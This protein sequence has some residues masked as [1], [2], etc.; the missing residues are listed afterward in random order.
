MRA[1]SHVGLAEQVAGEQQAGADPVLVEIAE[2]VD[3][4]RGGCGGEGEREAE[5]GWLTI[6]GR[7]GQ[8]QE[9]GERGQAFAQ[10]V[11]IASPGGDEVG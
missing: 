1:T 3:T 2:Q 11:E 10:V 7:L 6:R 5:P 9:F 4:S 8:D